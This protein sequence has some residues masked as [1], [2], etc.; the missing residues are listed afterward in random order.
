M[1]L[2]LFSDVHRDEVAARQLVE[3]SRHVDIAVGAGDFATTRRGLPEIIDV[4][5]RMDCKTVLVPGNSESFEELSGACCDWNDAYVLH[6]TSCE[7]AGLTFF[8]LGGAVPET[9]FGSWS[10]DF[11]EEQAAEL[12][13]PC[14]DGCVLV[15]H[16]PPK[17]VLDESSSGESLG[18]TAVREAVLSKQPSLV[19]CG[20]IHASGGRQATFK[21][22]QVVNAGPKGVLVNLES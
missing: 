15:S 21:K 14:P 4:L 13:A 2:L 10:Y 11:S 19:V 1:K 18:S 7:I 6:G 3:Q 9:P 12:L 22:T 20:H 17:G 8:G 5:S 16:S